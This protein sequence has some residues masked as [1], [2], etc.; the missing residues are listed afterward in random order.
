MYKPLLRP[1]LSRQTA[2]LTG[3]EHVAPSPQRLHTWLWKV[4]TWGGAVVDQTGTDQ[5]SVTGSAECM[6]YGNCTSARPPLRCTPPEP[7]GTLTHRQRQRQLCATKDT[8]IG[9]TQ[10][11]T[12]ST[13]AGARANQLGNCHSQGLVRRNCT[14]CNCLYP[15]SPWQRPH[16][17]EQPPMKR[18][19]PLLGI[20]EPANNA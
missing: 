18:P 8:P 4:P 7:F 17:N 20:A 3:P 2:E 15:S 13:G 10:K 16:A 9:A 6:E 1:I 11:P 5:A 14:T 12:L 19:T